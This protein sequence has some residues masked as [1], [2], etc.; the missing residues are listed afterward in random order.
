MTEDQEVET[1]ISISQFQ[2]GIY[3][4]DVKNLKNLYRRELK[5]KSKDEKVDLNILNKFLEEHIFKIEKIFKKFIKDISLIIL[6]SKSN[7]ICFGVKK[8]NL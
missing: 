2:I 5:Y 8:K 4:F 1:Y 3:F 6:D 7:N